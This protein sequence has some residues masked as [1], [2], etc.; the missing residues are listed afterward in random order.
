MEDANREEPKASRR[1]VQQSTRFGKAKRRLPPNG[2]LALD[3][4]VKKILANPLLGEMKVGALKGVRVLKFKL[5]PLQLLLAYQF[6]QRRNV[7]EL[8]DVGP[9]ENFYRDLDSYLRRR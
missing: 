6:N 3:E 2:Q 4:Q 9:H 7:I 1:T 5:G 8:L